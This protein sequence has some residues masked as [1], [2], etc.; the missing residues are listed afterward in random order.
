M[1]WSCCCCCWIA[2]CAWRSGGLCLR[3]S[4]RSRLSWSL[5]G[6]TSVVQTVGLVVVV[7]LAL[8]LLRFLVVLPE[9]RGEVAGLVR[10]LGV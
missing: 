8:V 6:Q 5:E 2:W 7:L 4:A 10:G 3:W 1:C 9:V